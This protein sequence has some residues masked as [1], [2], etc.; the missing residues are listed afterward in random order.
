MVG[1]EEQRFFWGAQIAEGRAFFG[2]PRRERVEHEDR[3]GERGGRGLEQAV[4]DR[5]G[6]AEG[7]GEIERGVP[8]GPD[9]HGNVLGMEEPRRRERV[10]ADLARS[11]GDLHP[12]GAPWGGSV[13]V[14]HEG[15]I[16]TEASELAGDCDGDGRLSCPAE[17]R[18]PHADDA[19]SFWDLERAP[20]I[21]FGDERP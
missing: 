2:A 1:G 10:V 9:D 15:H 8:G 7:E 3:I 6:R 19:E 12:A 11:I 17:D 20:H 21:F 16:F 4:N 5:D 13:G 18:A 14:A